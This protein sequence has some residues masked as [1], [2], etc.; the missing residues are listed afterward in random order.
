MIASGEENK[1]EVDQSEPSVERWT[2]EVAQWCSPK[3]LLLMSK[4]V[5]LKL[6][7]LD[8]ITPF[9]LELLFD[10]VL[11]SREYTGM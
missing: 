3:N 1:Y 9:I 2:K 10:L 8:L 4:H 6:L 5:H 7:E 11:N